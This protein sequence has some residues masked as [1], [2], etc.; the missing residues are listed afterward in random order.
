[1]VETYYE[2]GF[3]ILTMTEHGIVNKGWNV[4][5]KQLQ[6]L[7]IPVQKYPLTSLTDARYKEMTVDGTGRGGRIMLDVPMGMS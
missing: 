6:I 7:S 4:K 2:K 3:D 5:P 1:M